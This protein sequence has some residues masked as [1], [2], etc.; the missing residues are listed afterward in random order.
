VERIAKMAIESLVAFGLATFVLLL[1]SI[2]A[3][4]HRTNDSN[5]KE[6]QHHNEP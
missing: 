1:V 4:K 6:K 3:N 5:S 2:Y